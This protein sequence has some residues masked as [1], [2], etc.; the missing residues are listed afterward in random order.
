MAS[1]VLPVGCELAIPEDVQPGRGW[2]RFMLEMAAHIGPYATLLLCD[3]FGGREIYVPAD[4]DKSPFVAVIGEE[5]AAIVA[6]VYRRERIAIPTARYALNRA[7]RGAILAAVRAGS[8]TVTQAARM[9]GLRRDYVST[10]KNAGDEGV[11]VAP[12]PIARKH[13]P[14]QLDMF[15]APEGQG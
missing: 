15:K 1:G 9:L 3:R 5:R 2:S 13:D 4:A 10:L 6:R 12:A 11:G 7:R 8:L 14:R